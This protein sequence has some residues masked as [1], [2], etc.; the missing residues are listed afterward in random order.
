LQRA[1]ISCLVDHG[2]AFTTTRLVA[3]RA[4]VSRGAQT[5]HYPTKTDLVIAA[6]EHLFDDLLV[7]FHSRFAAIPEAERSLDR[8]IGEAWELLKGPAYFAVLEVI[9]AG[10]TDPE[11]GIVVH[12]VAV[13]LEQ[14][15]VATLQ[16]FFPEIEDPLLARSIIDL[17]FTILQG[18]AVAG[19]AGYGDP[20]ATVA[21]F[22]S[23]TRLI[24]PESADL[25]RYLL[26]E[27]TNP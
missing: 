7:R 13:H 26:T 11:L 1:T 25:L 20:D 10:R 24:T 9:V 12:G 16:A 23:L 6:I 22:R 27:G 8:A 19:I 18:A 17:G 15:V 14:S 5:H 3:E 2:Y 4:G 21:T